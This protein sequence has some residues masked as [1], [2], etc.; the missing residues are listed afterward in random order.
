VY[1]DYQSLASQVSLGSINP[2]N[3]I[4]SVMTRNPDV[5]KADHLILHQRRV[6]KGQIPNLEEIHALYSGYEKEVAQFT[7]EKRFNRTKIVM[8]V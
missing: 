2:S 8:S 3:R 7:D 5:F 1:I 4:F 6:Q